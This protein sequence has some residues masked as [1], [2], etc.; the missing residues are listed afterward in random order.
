MG[1]SLADPPR[2]CSASVSIISALPLC[3]LILP[4]IS[5]LFACKLAHITYIFESHGEHDDCER[6]L[7]GVGAETKPV[8]TIFRPRYIQHF[9]SAT[10][11]LADVLR[12][13]RNRDA[14]GPSAHGAED[15]N[16]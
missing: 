9:A 3:D 5:I 11:F 13:V 16:E 6:A 15:D 12:S 2:S 7:S 4:C 8:R 1:G 10:R 14:M